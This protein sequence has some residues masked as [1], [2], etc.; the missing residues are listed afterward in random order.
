MTRDQIPE[1]ESNV[2]CMQFIHEINARLGITPGHNL[3][4]N[5]NQ[6]MRHNKKSPR[7]ILSLAAIYYTSN[8]EFYLPIQHLLGFC[9]SAENRFSIHRK[10]VKIWLRSGLDPPRDNV[11]FIIDFVI[12]RIFIPP[13]ISREITQI[14]SVIKNGLEN[15]SGPNLKLPVLTCMAFSIYKQ[16]SSRCEEICELLHVSKNIVKKNIS[17]V[18][19]SKQIV[20]DL[21][22]FGVCADTIH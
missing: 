22:H 4:L 2:P 6:M 11:Q 19:C 18:M 13:K 7:N 5:L 3:I 20:C 1:T 9:E 12:S 14:M 10:F 21:N 16:T 8:L 17:F 15:L